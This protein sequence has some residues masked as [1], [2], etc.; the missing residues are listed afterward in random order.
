LLYGERQRAFGRLQEEIIKTMND[1]TV[2]AWDLTPSMRN[3]GSAGERRE[4]QTRSMLAPSPDCFAS[5]RGLVRRRIP[6]PWART[7]FQVTQ[8]GLEITAFFQDYEF[9]HH[10]VYAILDCG[11]KHRS[12][13]YV[14]LPLVNSPEDNRK[15]SMY[16]VQGTEYVQGAWCIPTCTLPADEIG[17]SAVNG[18]M[19]KVVIPKDTEEIQRT[20]G[21]PGAA[22][23]LSLYNRNLDLRYMHPV[24]EFES[25]LP[26]NKLSVNFIHPVSTLALI[27]IQWHGQG[28]TSHGTQWYKTPGVQSNETMNLGSTQVRRGPE[29]LNSSLSHHPHWT[30]WVKF[31]QHAN[32]LIDWE[33]KTWLIFL[34]VGNRR[35]VLG[36]E[37]DGDP[38]L[39]DTLRLRFHAKQYSDEYSISHLEIAES[40]LVR[41]DDF[42]HTEDAQVACTASGPDSSGTLI[43]DIGPYLRL[44][45]GSGDFKDMLKDDRV[46]YGRF[47]RSLS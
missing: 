21:R 40:L 41:D 14:A 42:W 8:H 17:S 47:V 2:L 13:Y 10:A 30:D 35:L 46:A 27:Q 16:L 26:G 28:V 3:Q 7:S 18:R 43:V 6:G 37:Y 23:R 33:A 5:A 9:D 45:L 20:I 12:R 15:S 1:P 36:I 25:H 19:R 34:T 32:D 11:P 4:R 31:G 29:T 24:F 38:L 39:G 22:A 44:R